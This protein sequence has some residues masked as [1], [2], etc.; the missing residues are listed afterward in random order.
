M[1]VGH[2]AVGFIAKPIA[3]KVSLGTLMGASLF[4]DLLWSILLITG[5]EHARIKPGI[6]VAN[7]LDLYDYPISHSLLTDTIWAALL[8][9]AYFLGSTIY[10]ELGCSS[11]PFLATGCS[12]SRVTGPICPSRQGSTDILD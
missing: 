3:S 4:P 6:T 2:L 8:A 9:T 12:T 10:V 5:I 1:F 7:P 11:R